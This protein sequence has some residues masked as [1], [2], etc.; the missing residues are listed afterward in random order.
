MSLPV[1]RMKTPVYLSPQ[2]GGGRAL[3]TASSC[4]GNS[5]PYS[6]P[7]SHK[8]RAVFRL[9]KPL[10]AQ[11]WYTSMSLTSVTSSHSSQGFFLS[12]SALSWDVLPPFLM[13]PPTQ[14][15]PPPFFYLAFLFVSHA[16]F[17]FVVN[18]Y[19]CFD[20]WALS[21]MRLELFCAAYHSVCWT[22]ALCGMS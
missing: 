20:H 21:S 22:Q 13:S 6:L 11:D 15:T 14:V 17:H 9:S 2:A 18:C 19:L 7:S 12:S 5:H 16:I 10:A 8:P 1:P 4:E 3:H